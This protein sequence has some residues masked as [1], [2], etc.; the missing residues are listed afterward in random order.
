MECTCASDIQV[1]GMLIHFI[2]TGGQHAYGDDTRDILKNLEKASPQLKTSD[3]ELQDILTWML[4]LYPVE[5]PTIY[6]VLAYASL[7]ILS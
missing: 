4:L 6:Q 3:L 2:L 7:F 1:A 5:R